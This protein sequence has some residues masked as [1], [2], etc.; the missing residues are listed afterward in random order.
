MLWTIAGI[1]CRSNRPIIPPGGTSHRRGTAR[2]R[3]PFGEGAMSRRRKAQPPA[4]AEPEIPGYDAVLSG[5]FELLESARRAAA[6]SVNAVMTAAYWE[7]G[8]R[9]VEHE[10]QGRSRAAYGKSLLARLSSDLTRRAGRG[11][12]VDNLELMRRF[13]L[14]Y[15]TPEISETSSRKSASGGKGRTLSDLFAAPEE[16]ASTGPASATSS[17][18]FFSS[19]KRA[20]SSITR[21]RDRRTMRMCESEASGPGAGAPGDDRPP[22][23][24]LRDRR[25]HQWL[26]SAGVRG[27]TAPPGEVAGR[28]GCRPE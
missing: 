6:R 2:D 14:A 17:V 7:M 9:I 13:Y 18:E 27:M 12:S 19:V 25:G 8:R 10:Q 16:P 22:L 20:M 28:A 23:R 5:L 3:G 1:D 24:G 4:A 11:F 21:C 26:A 15:P